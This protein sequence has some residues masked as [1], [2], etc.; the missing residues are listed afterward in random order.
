MTRLA[1]AP[2]EY[3]PM[4]TNHVMDNP[5]CA[6]WAGMGLGKGVM[7]LTALANLD[8]V[9]D[10]FPALAIGPLRVARDVWPNE[11]DKWEHLSHLHCVPI[12]GTADE[13]LRAVA[14]KA[15]I[16]S[17]NYE[18]LAWLLKYWGEERWPYKTVIA[19]E[20]TKLKGYRGS[21]QTSSTG[22]VFLRQ[23]GGARA[24]ALGTVTHT[25]KVT[26][27]IELTGTPA[28]N[29]LKDLW[30]QVWYL[31]A[32]K[33]LGR[34]FEGFASRWFSSKRVG[35]QVTYT[36]T[37]A[38]ANGE[39]QE[40]LTDLC[41]TIDAKD[42]FDLKEPIVNNIYVDLPPAVRKLYDDME[43]KLFIE[44]A[45]G[46]VEAFSQAAK[47]QKCLQLANGAVYLD[48][49]VES[50]SDPKAKQWGEVH[51]LKMEVLDSV[52]EESA[53][54]TM[55]IV[56]TFRSDLARILKKY[57]GARDLSKKANEKAFKAGNVQIGVAHPDSLGHG[58][59]G[60]QFVCNRIVHFGHGWPLDTYQQINERIGPVRQMQ[61]G[62]DRPVYHTHIL[63]RDT[64]DEEVMER[65]EGKRTV[66]EILLD[67]AKRRR[68]K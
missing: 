35:P 15:P 21:Y 18:N 14:C 33:R 39:I 38:A 40:R 16:F 59:D 45:S 55:I 64:L 41:L 23:N 58:V 48:H 68:K 49:T 44:I 61:A 57:P 1:Y 47:S 60:M 12:A 34:T 63:A 9:E 67:A 26:R 13:R 4:G 5:R 28:P 36:P 10:V 7:V 56:Y 53:G 27:F 52:I 32:G 42:Y 24:R 22:K 31:D 19:D 66:Q 3:Q 43:S 51:T 20:S 29:G 30:G 17:I 50:D 8:M 65:R 46:T 6:L 2:R 37:A 25:P 62:L 54:A 11:C